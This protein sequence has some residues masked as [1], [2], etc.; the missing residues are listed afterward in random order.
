MNKDLVINSIIYA[1][2]SILGII[3]PLIT[4]PYASNVLGP[5]GIGRVEYA[6]SISNYFV[7]LAALGIATYAVREGGKVKDDHE[8]LSKLS[9]ELLVINFCSAAIAYFGILIVCQIPAFS[10]YS[11]LIAINSMQIAF[12]AVG[13]EWIFTVKEEFRYITVRYI[14]VEIAAIAFLFLFVKTADDYLMYAVYVL[15]ATCGANVVNIFCL[16]RHVSPFKRRRLNLR[17]HIKPLLLLFSIS[18]TTVIFQNIDT[19]LLGTLGTDF[20]VGI[21]QT[22]MKVHNIAITVIAS[23]ST[24]VFA[25]GVSVARDDDGCVTKE[26]EE[27]VR[28]FNGV[29]MMICVPM[30]FGLC[31][32]SSEIVDVLLSEEYKLSGTVLSIISFNLIF[33]ALGRIYGH[34]I[35]VTLERDVLFFVST[36]VSVLIDIVL[37][38]ALIPLLGAVGPAIATLLACGVAAAMNVRWAM[39]LIDTSGYFGPSLKYLALSAP[40]FVIA[41][42]LRAVLPNA[43]V[44]LITT[45]I[46]CVAFYVVGLVSTKDKYFYSLLKLAKVRGTRS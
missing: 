21:F 41:A 1:F 29:M 5:E 3:F 43:M 14:V 27:L 16:S 26:F 25:H 7:Y 11:L 20:D 23:V 45:I 18:I 28:N 32:T 22:G 34:Q 36:L 31:V 6:N 38:V 17:R 10:S 40:F 33:N 39:G 46:S 24:A 42:I 19:T 2:R 37:D 15:I 4:F 13:M 9:Q 30:A 44:T 35:L 8:A 12:A